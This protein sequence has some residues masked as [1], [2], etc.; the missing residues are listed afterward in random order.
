MERCLSIVI[1]LYH[2]HSADI[3]REEEEEEEKD[4]IFY[5][6]YISFIFYTRTTCTAP[7]NSGFER[8]F[9]NKVDLPTYYDPS[10]IF[11]LLKTS[12]IRAN[13]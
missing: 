9:I 8:H 12:L 10:S 7:C 2:D 13:P 3:G 6:T 5:H 11:N 1:K 4:V